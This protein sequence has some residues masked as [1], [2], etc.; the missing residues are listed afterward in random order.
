MREP[1]EVEIS[2]LEEC[3]SRVEAEVR[4]GLRGAPWLPKCTGAE[5]MLRPQVWVSGPGVM[6]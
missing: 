3:L 2:A 4:C 6:R 5:R 1:G